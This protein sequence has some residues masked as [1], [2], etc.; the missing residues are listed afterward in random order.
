MNLLH[1]TNCSPAAATAAF[2]PAA[3]L[4]APQ[5]WVQYFLLTVQL[6]LLLLLL[7][8]VLQHPW[9]RYTNH[10][11]L[12]VNQLSS[13]AKEYDGALLDIFHGWAK[14]PDWHKKYLLPD[15]LH[16]NEEGNLAV[17]EG[18]LSTLETS[19]PEM[20]PRNMPIVFPKMSDIDKD[21]PEA[22]FEPLMQQAEPQGVQERGAVGSTGQGEAGGQGSQ[23]EGSS[24][25]SMTCM[26][27]SGAAML[28][29]GAAVA[30]TLFL[31]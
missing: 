24:S 15:N 7:L 18:I 31:S 19:I 28:F 30:A 22:A 8:L 27:G 10:T 17:H 5:A 16:L 2:V 12:Y 23:A 3:C 14:V 11:E 1:A 29:V 25:S 4:T 6:L 9:D 26:R 21:H 20:H 13:L